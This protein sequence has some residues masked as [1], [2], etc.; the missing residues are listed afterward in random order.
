MAQAMAGDQT[1]ADQTLRRAAGVDRLFVPWF[2]LSRAWATAAGGD[3][4]L[5]V[6]QASAAADLAMASGQFAVEAVAR[7]DVARLGDPKAA[8]RRLAE[9]TEVVQGQLVPAMAG[10]AA[11]LAS[12]DAVALDRATTTFAWL[13]FD[14]L[15]A[16]TATAAAVLHRRAGRTFLADQ[17]A[18]RASSDA[19][20]PMLRLATALIGLTPRE[21]DVALL[22]AAGLSSQTIGGR[23]RLSVR[24]VDN[25][26][27]R[28]YQK[29]GVANRR[30]LGS[31][32]D[33]HTS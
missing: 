23:L 30:D 14:L 25:Y 33:G 18:A 9:L 7:Y 5:A 11:A 1:G 4:S 28:I 2:E 21:R 15:A 31:L 22:A 17:A 24:T 3:A 16:E 8:R 29:L 6:R 12:S 19:A 13:G 26:L 20:T 10:A 32:V 27:G